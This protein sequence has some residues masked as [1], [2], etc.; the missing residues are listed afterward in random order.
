MNDSMP[1]CVMALTL[2]VL[3]AVAA[4]DD[5]VEEEWQLSEQGRAHFEAGR[6]AEAAEAFERA[7]TLIPTT[8]SITNAATAYVYAG[9]CED[10]LTVLQRLIDRA[11]E[12]RQDTGVRRA[13]Q[14]VERERDA[15]DWRRCS[16]AIRLVRAVD[17]ALGLPV[18]DDAPE[19]DARDFA[20][21]GQSHY[22]AG[23]YAS[24]ALFFQL[25]YDCYPIA[26]ALYNAA[27][28]L[29]SAG[30]HGEAIDVCRRFVAD[31]PDLSAS[32]G[33]ARA[34][35]DST[36]GR[37][38]GEVES[39]IQF[40]HIRRAIAEASG[41]TVTDLGEGRRLWELGV[42]QHR[43]GE[44]HAAA[45]TFDCCNAVSPH[46]RILLN[47][48]RCHAWADDWRPAL[49]YF[50]RYLGE[51]D[52]VAADPAVARARSAFDDEPDLTD[53]RAWVLINRLNWAIERI[54]PPRGR[55]SGESQ[56]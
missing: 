36:T 52:Q 27:M 54:D 48:A 38:A 46:P 35:G 32:D 50:D 30:R 40:S 43:N 11:A 5:P 18:A 15:A 29:H 37:N 7:D 51:M 49:E 23:W 44:Y 16:L 4:A 22:D 55:S 10:A 20:Q 6:Y 8:E 2:A 47:V 31:T 41:E 45:V 13:T 42:Q 33:V 3:A 28:A 14:I 24:A 56:R 9:L 34:L 17:M 26:D 39:C 25:S 19:M 21:V 1:R 53:E 12:I